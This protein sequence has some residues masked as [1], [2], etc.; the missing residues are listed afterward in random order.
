L[1]QSLHL[2][3]DPSQQGAS[4]SAYHPAE[5]RVSANLGKLRRQP[6]QGLTTCEKPTFT[7][8]RGHFWEP[9]ALAYH[10]RQLG[11]LA[12][13]WI[14]SQQFWHTTTGSWCFQQICGLEASSS[15]TPLQRAGGSSKPVDEGDLQYVTFKV[16]R[17][18]LA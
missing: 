12:C 4:S 14:G 13:M 7:I 1:I 17:L 18:H 5:L 2:K 11:V 8:Y 3:V 6:G 15:G 10:H 16:D 9:V